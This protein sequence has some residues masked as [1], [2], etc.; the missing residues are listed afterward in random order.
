MVVA[1][2]RRQT[3]PDAPDAPDGAYVNAVGAGQIC[4]DIGLPAQAWDEIAPEWCEAFL[5]G[6][7]AAHSER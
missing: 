7:R 6:Y 5:R 2:R 3:P 4:R 1:A